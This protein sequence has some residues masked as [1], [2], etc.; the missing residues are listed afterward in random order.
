MVNEGTLSLYFICHHIDP[1]S[2]IKDGRVIH[3]TTLEKKIPITWFF[4]GA[5]LRALLDNRDR[6]RRELGFDL[7]DA[8]RGGDF[9]NPRFGYNNPYISEIAGMT[10]N[11]VP[12]VQPWFPD[13][14]EYL[15]GI[16]PDQIQRT[17]DVA[18]YDFDKGIVTFHGPDGTSSPSP[19]YKLKQHGLDTLIISGEFLNGNQQA[20]GK[21]YW[22]SGLRHLVRDNSL[23]IQARE[24]YD[25]RRFIDAAQELG[26]QNGSGFVV[27]GSDSNEVNGMSQGANGM[28]SR[29]GIARICCIADEAYRRGVKMINCN[30]AAHLNR[31]YQA[32]LQSIWPN[33]DDIHAMQNPEGNLS[34]IDDGRNGEIGHVV[35]L[36]GERHRQGWDGVIQRAKEHLYVAADSALRHKGFC[37]DPFL[38]GI[39]N[40]NIGRARELLQ[41]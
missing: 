14:R 17:L 38:T 39:Y 2:I 41:G 24:F 12:L 23:Q 35:W 8:M 36:I 21:V 26:H 20:K 31:F 9:I 6:I 27:S 18:R 30:A 32:D 1:D 22:A 40:Y 7:V 16:L 28:N 37:Y 29:D 5:Q 15:E 33:W 13:Q 3:R 34:W 25:A 11:H 4:S 10:Y 19:A